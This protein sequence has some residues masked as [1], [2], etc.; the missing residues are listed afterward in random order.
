M[1]TD[2]YQLPLILL[3]VMNEDRL[4]SISSHFISCNE[5]GPIARIYQLPLILLVVMN[6]DRLLSIASHFISCNEWGPIARIYQL[7]LILL[8]V[9]KSSVYILF[10]PFQVGI[11]SNK[12]NI[13]SLLRSLHLAS[14]AYRELS[15]IQPA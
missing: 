13:F 14:A 6:E 3:V 15:N 2:C 8:V 1:R 5:W 12:N 11:P 10:P 9:M 7:P 4:L